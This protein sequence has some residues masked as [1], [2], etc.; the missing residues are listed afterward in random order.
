MFGFFPTRDTKKKDR[1]DRKKRSRDDN[2]DDARP[3]LTEIYLGGLDS[4][5]S[6][7]K[8]K[9]K[10]VPPASHKDVPIHFHEYSS[11][12]VGKSFK[13]MSRKR[14]KETNYG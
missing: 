9:S 1:D 11:R 2:T 4:G 13:P 3:P 6:N 12:L 10:Y 8:N 14:R 7:S 5:N